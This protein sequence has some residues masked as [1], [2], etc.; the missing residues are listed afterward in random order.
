MKN[1]GGG[2]GGGAR[3]ARFIF[4]EVYMLWPPVGNPLIDFRAFLLNKTWRGTKPEVG[5]L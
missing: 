4:Q 5:R 3:Q 2:G 1:S